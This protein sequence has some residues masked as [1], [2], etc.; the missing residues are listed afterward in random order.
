MR[1]M[2]ILMCVLFCVVAGGCVRS[3]QPVLTSEQLV[4]D[5]SIVGSWT[6][7]DDKGLVEVQK[8]GQD[9]NYKVLYTDQDGKKGTFLIRLGKIQDM[10]IAEVRPDDPAPAAIDVYKAHLLP[11]YS[12]LVI[13][14]TTPEIRFSVMKAEW[15]EKY[16]KDHPDELRISPAGEGSKPGWVITSSTSD[17]Q[18]F[19]LRHRN[20]SEAFGEEGHLVRKGPT[21]APA[22]K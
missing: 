10:L 1:A 5:K 2:R 9:K 17:I 6:P 13:H 16:L 7:S 18:A 11:L 22:T 21:T 20:D 19:L 3:I 4:V 15:L 12:F 8:P 14:Q